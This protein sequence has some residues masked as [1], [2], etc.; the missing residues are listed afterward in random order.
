MSMRRMRAGN[1]WLDERV[2]TVYKTV[3]GEGLLIVNMARQLRDSEVSSLQGGDLWC[4]SIDTESSLWRTK[5][6]NSSRKV[7]P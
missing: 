1:V 2:E 3:V 6:S 4:C 7:T 5:P